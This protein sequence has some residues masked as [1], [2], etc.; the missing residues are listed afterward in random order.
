M[1][2]FSFELITHSK[3]DINISEENC[4]EVFCIA[5]GQETFYCLT[6]YV[7]NVYNWARYFYTKNEFYK[8]IVSS[9]TIIIFIFTEGTY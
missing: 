6:I 8:P 3:K 7:C 9:Y 5:T 4:T 1:N 2:N